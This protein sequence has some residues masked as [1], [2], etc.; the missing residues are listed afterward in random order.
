[1]QIHGEYILTNV[2]NIIMVS[3]YYCELLVPHFINIR[4][5]NGIEYAS[6]PVSNMNTTLV[7]ML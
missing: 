5:G 3:V 7:M 4:G 2:P 6:Q 1:M